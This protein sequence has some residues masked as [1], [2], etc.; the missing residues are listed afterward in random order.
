MSYLFS[1]KKLEDM[2]VLEQGWANVNGQVYVSIYEGHEDCRW[3]E[4]KH[5]PAEEMMKHVRD[6][7]FPFIKNIHDGERFFR[8]I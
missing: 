1:M 2:D 3:S 5:K 6:V 4:W 8:S 7:V